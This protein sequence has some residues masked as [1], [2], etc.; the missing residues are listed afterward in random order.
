[1]MSEL[2]SGADARIR[3]ADLLITNHIL[4]FSQT[5]TKRKNIIDI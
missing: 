3:T 1:M 2:F 4:L 5:F